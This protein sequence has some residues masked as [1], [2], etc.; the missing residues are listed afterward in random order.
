MSTSGVLVR[1]LF[2][3]VVVVI[4]LLFNEKFKR[5]GS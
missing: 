3:V 4:I 1:Y 2:L 5:V